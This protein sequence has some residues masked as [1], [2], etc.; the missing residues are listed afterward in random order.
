MG[1]VQNPIHILMRF[2]MDMSYKLKF[3]VELAKWGA[4]SIVQ[5]VTNYYGVDNFYKSVFQNLVE[6]KELESYGRELGQMNTEWVNVIVTE[7]NYRKTRGRSENWITLDAWD[8][9]WAQKTEVWGKVFHKLLEMDTKLCTFG[10]QVVHGILPTKYRISRGKLHVMDGGKCDCCHRIG[11]DEDETVEH[12]LIDCWVA[13]R[14]WDKVNLALFKAGYREIC[15]DPEEIIARCNQ[16]GV[17][18]YI[19]TQTARAIWTIRCKD[20]LGEERRTWQGGVMIIKHRLNIRRGLDMR[21]GNRKMWDKL[22]LFMSN[23]GVT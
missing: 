1:W 4:G 11:R 12:L 6:L 21:H 14:V 23:L 19:L 13:A 16:S 10:W 18:N 7:E 2:H 17:E 22:D 9:T 15:K 5:D 8:F 20:Y 3:G